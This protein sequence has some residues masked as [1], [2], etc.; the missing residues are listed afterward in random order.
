MARDFNNRITLR[1]ITGYTTDAIGNQIPNFIDTIV[2]ANKEEV[3]ASDFF[4]SLAHNK[5]IEAEYKIRANVWNNQ[6]IAIADGIEYDIDRGIEAR[7]LDFI[8]LQLI[9]RKG[10]TN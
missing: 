7:N 3:F 1:K 2:W 5:R 4:N 6:E 8:I 9:R 10:Q